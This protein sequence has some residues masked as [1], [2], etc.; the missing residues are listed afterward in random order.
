MAQDDDTDLAARSASLGLRL[1]PL[2][3]FLYGG[4]MGATVFAPGWMAA[5]VAGINVAVLSGLVLIVV[6]L[7]LALVYVTLLRRAS[8]PR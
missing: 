3:L 1:F 6:A 4:Y 2:Y 5:T 7:L 8:G